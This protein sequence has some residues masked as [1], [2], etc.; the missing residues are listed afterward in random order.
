[1]KQEHFGAADS[2]CSQCYWSLA[3]PDGVASRTL[4]DCTTRQLCVFHVVQ[5]LLSWVACKHLEI[6]Q[7]VCS[8]LLVELEIC[9]A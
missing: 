9:L 1:M 5:Y 8:N 7:C 6:G 3:S 4:P 2:D